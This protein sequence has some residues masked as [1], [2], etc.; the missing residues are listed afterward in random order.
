MAEVLAAVRRHR[1][2]IFSAAMLVVLVWILWTARGALPAFVIGLALAL[3]LDPGVTLLN[4]RGVPRWIGV[5][6]MYALVVVFFWAV[7]AFAVPPVAAQLTDFLE[8]LP[9]L[10]DQAGELQG[11]LNDWYESLAIP[12]GLRGAINESIA[13][14]RAAIGDLLSGVAAPFAAALF[15]TATFVLGLLIIPI[16]LFFVLK[17][18]ERLPDA[19]STALPPGWRADGRN[20]LGLMARVGGRWVRG[21]LLLGAAIFAATAIGLTALTLLGYEEFG[22]FTLILALIAGIL[23][24]LPIIGPVIAAIP[25]LLIAFT[26]DPA[27]VVAV[28]ILY[29]VIQQLENNLLVPKVMGDAIELH[30]AVMIL[31]LVVGGALFGFWGAILAAP[32]VAIGRDLYRYGFLRLSGEVPQPAF[33]MV[34]RG[35]TVPRR[36]ESTVVVVSKSGRAESAEPG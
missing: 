28:V 29:T 25:A 36:P 18:R 17:D 33:E 6:A 10:G 27:A 12:D 23:E 1:L 19:I 30:P 32:V 4:R 31:A 26:I 15:R 16:W 20:V 11:A 35:G 2:E 3:V 21:Q 34:S 14:G 8:R 22:R 7:F 13:T 9:E 5:L 24:W